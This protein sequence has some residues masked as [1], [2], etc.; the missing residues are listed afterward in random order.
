MGLNSPGWSRRFLQKER[1]QN[2]YSRDENGLI[3][4]IC[5]QNRQADKEIVGSS[6]SL[7]TVAYIKEEEEVEEEEVE[8]MEEEQD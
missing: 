2:K 7:D 3:L 1:L 5:R 6:C 8:Y 4:A